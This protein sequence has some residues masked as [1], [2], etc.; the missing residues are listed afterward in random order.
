MENQ[1]K[2]K[3]FFVS[4]G[5][6][7]HRWEKKPHTPMIQQKQTTKDV[8]KTLESGTKTT[9]STDLLDLF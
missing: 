2:E 8:K 5:G 7:I 1:E 4:G 3:R 9:D 6:D